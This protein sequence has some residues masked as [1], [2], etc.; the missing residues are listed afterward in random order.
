MILVTGAVASGKRTFVRG[1]G[2][3]ENDF[4]FVSQAGE[5]D[6]GGRVVVDAQL[7]A[8]G[9]VPSQEVLARLASTDVV[10]YTEVGAGVVPLDRGERAWRERAGRLACELAARATCVVRVVCGIPQVLGGS[11]PGVGQ[12]GLDLIIMRH[13]RTHGNDLHRYV[14]RTDEALTDEG[15]AQARHAGSCPRVPLVYVSPLARARQTAQICFPNAEQV[16]VDDLREMD[17]GDFE[18]RSA[19]D[20]AA[21]AAYRAWVDG[22]CVGRCPHGDS[23]ESFVTRCS[24]AVEGVV[25]RASAR[26]DRRVVIVAHGG[27]IMAAMSAFVDKPAGVIDSLAYFG[28]QVGNCEGYRATVLWSE[29]HLRLGHCQRFSDL[30]FLA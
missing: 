5:W 12:E 20:M 16:V 24:A 3:G 9:G 7:L 17:F 21:D 30:G 26:G 4:A 28:W 29:G 18:G 14:G 25:R 10:I 15:M 8:L 6:Q 23:R 13:G 1:L 22:S 27:T 19:N 2:Y 11:L